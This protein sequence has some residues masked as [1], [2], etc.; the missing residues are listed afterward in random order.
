MV[1]RHPF[2]EAFDTALRGLLTERP[3][4]SLTALY[5]VSFYQVSDFTASRIILFRISYRLFFGVRSYFIWVFFRD[6]VTVATRSHVL[7]LLPSAHVSSA[8]K[9]MGAPIYNLA[10]A[11]DLVKFFIV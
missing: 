1:K 3:P 11:R 6:S 7:F 9:V 4:F 2:P 10:G 8:S 5:A